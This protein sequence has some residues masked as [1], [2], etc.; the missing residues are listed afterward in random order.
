M[1]AAAP[2]PASPSPVPAATPA[3]V[4]VIGLGMMG[5][6]LAAALLG[7]GHRVTVWNRSPAR[8]GPLVAQGALPAGTAADAVAAAPLVI[9]CLLDNDSVR[10]VFAG[11]GGALAGKTLVNTTNGTPAQARELAAWAAEHGAR[12]V[13]GGIMAV[14]QMIA[15]PHAYVLYSGDEEAFQDCRPVLAA[16]GGTRWTG[17]DPGLA[18]LYDL[19]LL[20]G[21][22][23]MVI[24]VMQAF[25]LVRTEGIPAEEFSEL[26]VPWIGAMLSGAPQWAAAVDSGRHLTD[27]SSLA[28][29]HAAFPNFLTTFRDQGV[30]TE[31]FAPFQALLDRAMAQ[32][33]AADG[34]SRIADLLS[35]DAA[36]AANHATAHTT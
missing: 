19:G 11:L 35:A 16:F 8:T 30:S 23:G 31:L 13:D 12:Y 24:G 32:G 4:S 9:V 2:S 5:S 28:V 34:L 22:Y 6:A 10:K 27:V 25:A 26:L 14:P 3:S 20:T 15:G 1:P 33:Y 18:A 36:D 17:T 21:M 7:A 29:N